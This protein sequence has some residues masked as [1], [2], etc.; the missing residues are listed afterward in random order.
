MK[1]HCGDGPTSASVLHAASPTQVSRRTFL[2]GS[3]AAAIA[4]GA[5]GL[6][7]CAPEAQKPAD[8][9]K[10]A[11][12]PVEADA[13][14]NGPTLTYDIAPVQEEIYPGTCGGFCN[15]GCSYNLH[16][17]DGKLV[18][19]SVREMDD[20]DYT[21]VCQKGYTHPYRVYS[22]ERLTKPLRRVGEKG[23][24]QWEEIS[25]DEAI[26][27]I[28]EQ[29]RDL[30][31]QY[32][33]ET[34]A[35]AALTGTF[36]AIGG[37]FSTSLYTRFKKVTGMTTIGNAVDAATKYVCNRMMGQDYFNTANEPKDLANAKTIL[38]WGANPAVSQMQI[39]HFI[40][41][42]HAKGANLVVIDPLYNANTSLADKFVPIKSA[43]DGALALAMMNEVIANGWEDRDFLQNSTV[44]PFLVK[45]DHKFLRLSDLGLAEAGS[46]EDR[47]VVTDG[48]G[49]FDVPEKI[50]NPVIEGTFHAGDV[51]VTC[52]YTLLAERV[53]E[54][55]V[56]RA[57]EVTGIS[58]QDIRDLARMYAQDTPATIYT[59]FGADHYYNGH[60]N[61]SCM[62]ALALLTGNVG[63]SGAGIGVANTG[64]QNALNTKFAS[65]VP[66]PVEK[67]KTIQMLRIEDAILNH[68]YNDE[69]FE[70]HGMF[71][72]Y[73][74]PIANAADRN[75]TIEA[76]KELD[77]L[78]VVD[79]VLSETAEYADYVLPC[80]HWFEHESMMATMIMHPCLVYSAAALDPLGDSKSDFDILKLLAE[81]LGYGEHFQFDTTEWLKMILDNDEARQMGLTYESLTQKGSFRRVPSDK[82]FVFAEGGVFP[83]ATK[84][85][86]FYLED[87]KPS[88]DYQPDFDFEKE[89][90]PYWEEAMEVGEHSAAREKYPL[91]LI[92]EHSRF[93]TH[94]QW[95]D[96]KALMEVDDQQ[97]LYISPDDAVSYGIADGDKVRVFNDRGEFV[98]YARV[99]P[100]NP[101]G[102][103][104]AVKGWRADQVISGHLSNLGTKKSNGFC[105]NQPFND[106]AV[107]IEKA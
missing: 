79:M 50:T 32:G 60:W 62:V 80:S 47:P 86:A 46:E 100:N 105:A 45:P 68:S 17:R 56:E 34:I 106:V 91:Q 58:V 18:R 6:V 65:D 10:P 7:G 43:T 24:G 49:A 30:S 97:Y 14:P 51:E 94:T 27:E 33:P 16:V 11:N 78:V 93:R 1:S 85:A 20:P 2:R 9:E 35:T 41:E 99:R 71:L 77:L 63:K 53:A 75:R 90:L 73:V 26:S 67:A 87:P 88:N 37:N 15:G 95:G 48:E 72:S 36:E 101:Q 38:I 74:N 69:P 81:G 8:V 29:W 96:V 102:I 57:S 44:A 59:V 98:T 83:T 42:A 92:S 89:Y 103:V 66:S 13:E 23:S 40:T 52:A 107:A 19:V 39:M 22:S 31:D 28:C 12:E 4:A 5:V 54:W 25:W 82:T 3:A 104:S 84:R 21:R 70:L 64:K 76:F 61:Y 55:P